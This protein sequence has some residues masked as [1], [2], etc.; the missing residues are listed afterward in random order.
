MAKPLYIDND[1]D[2]F[3]KLEEIK[4]DWMPDN[5]YFNNEN[6]PRRSRF[7][8]NLNYSFDE[9]GNFIDKEVQMLYRSYQIANQMHSHC[10]TCFKY[11]NG[12][13]RFD[14]PF[15]MKE[16]GHSSENHY[17]WCNDCWID[18]KRDKYSKMRS[19]VHAQRNNGNINNCLV[20]SFLQIAH[21]GNL[22]CQYISN[23]YGASLYIAEYIS[24]QDVADNN[25]IRNVWV[26]KMAM[27]TLKNGSVTD[28]QQLKNVGQALASCVKVC[29]TNACWFLLGLEYVKKSCNVVN[30]NPLERKFI[31]RRVK[32]PNNK[33]SKLEKD[34]S[35]IEI[36]TDHTNNKEDE[37]NKIDNIEVNG[38][39]I[40]K[41]GPASHLGKRNAYEK[42]VQQQY[43]KYGD[44]EITF[45]AL[46]TYYSIAVPKK[47]NRE[48]EPIFFKINSST[49]DLHLVQN[50][51]NV[52]KYLFTKLKKKMYLI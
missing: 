22:D 12:E 9:S 7:N 3:A 19:K 35:E 14:F 31:N 51:F 39:S 52:E 37:E 45:F 18:T 47:I 21:G 34:E 41:D 38:E 32:I 42:L 43:K 20:N 25:S 8:P 30:I 33:A 28:Q 48:V 50:R 15:M 4:Y 27:K 17:E 29:S 36:K 23:I 49:G 44:C 46:L 13:C 11:N 24:K 10:F 16:A 40:L 6:D 2:T 26:K 5:N 1:D